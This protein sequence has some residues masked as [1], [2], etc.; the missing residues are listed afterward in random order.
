MSEL[1][2][3]PSSKDPPNIRVAMRFVLLIG[4]LSFFADFTYEIVRQV[5][6]LELQLEELEA[7]RAAQQVADPL[8][9]EAAPQY[10]ILG[11]ASPSR[12][13]LPE[14]LAREV[15]THLPEATCCT[16]CGGALR[17]F[18]EDVAEVLDY[19]KHPVLAVVVDGL[20]V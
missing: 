3:V 9:S 18:G 11:G 2:P 15:H 14:H 8:A 1:E 13:S 7:G 6:Q 17:A 12:R 5:E 16:G 19:G 10:P 4:V 20:S